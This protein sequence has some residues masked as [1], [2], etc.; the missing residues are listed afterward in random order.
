[1]DD[2]PVLNTAEGQGAM[3]TTDAK[4]LLAPPRPFTDDEL[5]DLIAAVIDGLDTRI[6]DPSVNTYRSNSGMRVEVSMT[7][8]GS[9]VK[10]HEWIA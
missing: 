1:L 5:T 8:D 2:Q 7:I 3:L 10:H 9:A 4:A 6:I